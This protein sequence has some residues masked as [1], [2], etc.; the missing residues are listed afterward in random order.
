[1]LEY[2]GYIKSSDGLKLFY[3]NWL[4]GNESKGQIFL[5]HGYSEHSGRYHSW[6]EKFISEGFEVYALDLRGHGHSE[7]RRG[8]TPSYSQMLDDIKEFIKNFKSKDKI[9]AI[10]YGQSMGG[11]LVLNYSISVGNGIDGII[12]TSPWLKLSK[13]PKSFII[14]FVRILRKIFPGLIRKAG[15]DINC[16]SHDK[17]VIEEYNKDPFTHQ[18]ISY[19]LFFVVRKAGIYAIEHASEMEVPTLLMHGTKDMVTSYGASREFTYN[20]NAAGKD[21]QFISWKGLY[22]ELHHEREKEKVF[23]TI[24][25]WLKSKFKDL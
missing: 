7:G 2:K 16:L 1:M 24:K 19:N 4:P 11:N 20:A 22:H 5:I 21:I 10:L 12:A 8:H 3:R 23:A 15:F 6:A 9:P 14:L 18:K 25:R 17:K 13:E